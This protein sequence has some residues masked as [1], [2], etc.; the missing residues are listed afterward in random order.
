MKVA[1]TVLRWLS[2]GA[3]AYHLVYALFVS[4]PVML[5]VYIPSMIILDI[6]ML[7]LILLPLVYFP[8]VIIMLVPVVSFVFLLVACIVSIVKTAT[9]KPDAA[10]GVILV[11]ISAPFS[12]TTFFNGIALIVW[13]AL[14]KRIKEKENVEIVEEIVE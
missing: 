8:M 2:L 4:L 11:A 9:N 10:S 6:T 3:S 7:P 12:S 5:F 14:R 13:S 1:S